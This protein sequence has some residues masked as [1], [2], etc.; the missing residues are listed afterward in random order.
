MQDNQRQ[1]LTQKQK[2]AYCSG[3]IDGDGSFCLVKAKHPNQNWDCQIRENKVVYFAG[4]LDAEGSFIFQK[5]DLENVLKMTN[6]ISPVYAGKIRIGMVEKEPLCVLD[7]T[8]PGG[9]ILC[10]GVRRGRPT[11]QVMYRWE[12]CK[13]ELVIL[14]LKEMIPFLIAKKERAITLLD[15][16]EKWRNPFN[17]K[18]GVDPEEL[19]R[20]EEAYQKMR[21]LNAVGA[22]ATTNPRSSGDAE[23]IV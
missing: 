23:V 5:C 15:A 12:L 14:A 10:E 2:I 6:R 4:L 11:Y 16:L 17:R 1:A 9:R 13:K 21:K 7:Q 3:L 8:F 18:I 19:Q 20:R 22:A